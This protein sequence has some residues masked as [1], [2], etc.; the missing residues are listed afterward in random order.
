MAAATAAPVTVQFVNPGKFTD[1]QVRGRD[2]NYTASRPVLDRKKR[3][4]HDDSTSG[5]DEFRLLV[6]RCQ[7]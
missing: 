4:S 6:N 2:A 7:R 1:F 5:P 3:K